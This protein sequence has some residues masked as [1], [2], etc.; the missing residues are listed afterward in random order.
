[1]ALAFGLAFGLGG[2]E[3][4]AQMWSDWYRRSREISK[5]QTAVEVG[6]RRMENERVMEAQRREPT[7]GGRY[8]ETR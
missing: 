6:S 4:A 7:D 2:R 5:V 1:L 3:T 8:R